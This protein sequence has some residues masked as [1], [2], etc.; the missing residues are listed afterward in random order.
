MIL[1]HTRIALILLLVFTLLTGGIY[2]VLVTGMAHLLFPMQSGGSL[3]VRNGRVLGSALIGQPFTSPSYFW[4]RP[5]AT[6]PFPYNGAASGGSNLAPSNPALRIRVQHDIVHL[7]EADTRLNALIPVDLVTSSA[8]GLD[9]HISP[10]AASMQI[11][12]VSRARGLTEN[13]LS[14]LVMH[15]TEGRFLGIFGEPRVNVLM[16]NLDLD[17][18]T[19]AK[20]RH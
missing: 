14:A 8:S 11:P 18:L 5:S 2:P 9:P 15:H 16:L 13:Q 19:R 12:R 7:R 20:G 4:S 10:D 3:I 1:K 6:V 17:D